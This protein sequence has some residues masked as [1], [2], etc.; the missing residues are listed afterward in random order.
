MDQLWRLIDFVA[1]NPFASAVIAFAILLVGSLF[2]MFGVMHA[3]WIWRLP[4]IRLPPPED[5]VQREKQI[6]PNAMN[7]IVLFILAACVLVTV[8]VWSG[9]PR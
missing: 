5:Q 8:W 3:Q 2:A 9:Q 4:M 6:V 7:G 1:A